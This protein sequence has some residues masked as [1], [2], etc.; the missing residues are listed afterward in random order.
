MKN[1]I[2]HPF[3]TVP[4][5]IKEAF[6]DGKLSIPEKNIL[7]H[8]R[9]MA[10]PYG[11]TVLTAEMIR[12]SVFDDNI[13]R[14]TVNKH[15][16]SLRDKKWIDYRNR[17]GS[18]GQFQ[19]SLDVWLYSQKEWKYVSGSIRCNTIVSDE[20]PNTMP[21]SE[22]EDKTSD[23]NRKQEY[24]NK[25]VNH[26]ETLLNQRLQIGTSYTYTDI[27]KDIDTDNKPYSSSL[28][29]NILVENFK[30]VSYEQEK[31][32]HIAKNVGEESM[33]FV[34]GIYDGHGE[35][36]ILVME[37]IVTQMETQSGII[38]RGKYFNRAVQNKL[39]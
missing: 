2:E 33:G 16:S 31:L 29:K 27:E 32:L 1:K 34:L 10:D 14:G 13:K 36:G 24:Q 15:L 18:G 12:G 11:K 8:L 30:P 37:K 23:N 6:L 4:H 28:K 9:M 19:I 17:Q 39:N 22:V 21:S 35:N 38:D 20:L 3:N 26:N 5:V 7:L 25:E